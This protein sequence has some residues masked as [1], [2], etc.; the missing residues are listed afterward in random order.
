MDCGVNRGDDSESGGVNKGSDGC[1][2]LQCQ[3]RLLQAVL[4]KAGDCDVNKG[5]DSESVDWC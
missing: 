1:I 2:L 4:S 3:C 5:G